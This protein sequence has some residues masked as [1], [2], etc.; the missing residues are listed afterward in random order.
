MKNTRA[1][2]EKY[3]A[4]QDENK[5]THVIHPLQLGT[6][7]IVLGRIN[8]AATLPQLAHIDRLALSRM[9]SLEKVWSAFIL[10][11]NSVQSP[12]V[13]RDGKKTLV[14][15]S[16]AILRGA[17]LR[18]GFPSD[19]VFITL[20]IGRQVQKVEEIPYTCRWIRSLL[21]ESCEAMWLDEEGR[22]LY[23]ACSIMT[24]LVAG[25][26]APGQSP[27]LLTIKLCLSSFLP[28]DL[29]AGPTHSIH[30]LETPRVTCRS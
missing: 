16:S 21:L 26:R 27:L 14:F 20:G 30:L 29:I 5:Q 11:I 9:Q 10:C 19:F 23:A 7:R 2:E 24:T 18:Q 22:S 4:E 17:V 12:F 13:L 25:G 8:C 15:L 6:D 3:S 1:W 28:S